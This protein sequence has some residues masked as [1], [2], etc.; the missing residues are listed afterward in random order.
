[1]RLFIDADGCP[2]TKIAVRAAQ[3]RGVP[4]TV[5]CDT[6][7]RFD[8]PGAEVI[9]VEQGADSADLRLVNMIQRGDIAVTQ[10]Y[11]L[12]ALCL[13]RGAHVL[14]QDGRQYTSENIDG[15]LAF[16]ALAKRIRRGGGRLRG[17]SKRTAAQDRAF[18]T[19]LGE[20]LSRSA[21][22]AP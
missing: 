4:C 2:V 15:L 22:D 5:I 16:R 6:S 18:E 14:D 13:S 1:M 3:A 17:A 11:G 9:T 20:M 10:D 12:A 8:L 7:H 19:A 21:A